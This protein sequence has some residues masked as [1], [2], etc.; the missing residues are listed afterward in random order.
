[1]RTPHD[2]LFKHSFEQ[3][4]NAASALRAI[5]PAALVRRADWS[6]LRVERGHFITDEQREVRSDLLFSLRVAGKKL[7]FYILKEHQSTAVHMMP[8]RVLSYKVAI[9]RDFLRQNPLARSLPP[10]IAVV[11]YHGEKPWY[12][13][14]TMSELFDLSGEPDL[15]L[16]LQQHLPQ[17]ALLLDDLS[18]VDET[19]IWQRSLTDIASL[20]LLLLKTARHS[21]TLAAD[22]RRWAETLERV[23]HAPMASRPPRRC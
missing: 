23:L 19:A 7:L 8:F 5:L 21:T 4:E 3:P 20:T 1:M 10:I 13:A 11:V 6:T 15:A 18:T 12:E 22:L 17:F 16:A 9:W 2:A 14:R